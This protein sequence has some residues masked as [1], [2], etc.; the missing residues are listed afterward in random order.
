[1]KIGVIGGWRVGSALAA[2]WSQRGHDVVVSA[3]DTVAETAAGRDVVVLAM[4]A[5]AARK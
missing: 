5:S 2:T 1:V 3:R 4:P